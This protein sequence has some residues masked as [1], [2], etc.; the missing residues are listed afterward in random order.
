MSERTCR[1]KIIPA[2]LAAVLFLAGA[3]AAQTATTLDKDDHARR[4]WEKSPHADK[5]S[6][7]FIHWNA[8]GSIPT[9]CAKCHSTPGYRDY[10]GADGSAADVVNSTAPIGTTIQCEAC[11]TDPEKG[12]PH[13]RTYVIFPSGAKVTGLGPEAMCMECHQ[14]RASTKDVDT[15]ISGAGLANEDTPSSKLRFINVHYF[16]AAATQF[17]TVAKGGYEYAGKT[18]DA[19][20]SHI[21]GYNACI[22]CHS[23]HSLE[24]E[25]QACNTC[26][27]GVK[28]PR[29]IRYM[30]SFEDYDG[31]GD[32]K[33]GMY[34]EV[35]HLKGYLYDTMRAYA[36]TV[37]KTPIAY[38]GLTYPYFFIDL[39]DNG[40]VDSNEAN[41]ANGYNKFTARLLRAAYNYQV[42]VKDPCGYVHNGKYIIELIYDSIEDLNTKLGAGGRTASSGLRRPEMMS[43]VQSAGAARITMKDK[44]LSGKGDQLP[45]EGPYGGLS[46]AEP[47]AAGAAH[48][49]LRRTDEGHFDGSGMP[50][51]DWDDTGVVPA[52]CAK[53]HSAQGL[54]TLLE[55]GAITTGFPSANGFLCSTCHTVPPLTHPAGPV[56]F[57]SGSVVDLHDS[58]NL[59]LNCHQGRASKKTV[60]T[61]IAASKGPYSFTNIH[62]F[63]AAASFF[64]SEVHGGYEFDG[65]TYAGRNIYTNH[66]GIF[67]DCVEC[68]FSTKSPNRKQDDSD[69]HFHNAAPSPEDCVSCHGQDISQPHPGGDPE[70]FEFEGIRPAQTPDYDADGNIRESLKSEIVGLEDKLYPQIQAYGKSI[71]AP[72]VY[73]PNAYPYWFKDL[74]GNGIGDPNELVSSNG[75]RFTAPMLRAAYNLHF[76]K[77]E[78]C[79]YIHNPRYFAQLLVDS[80]GHLGGDVSPYTWR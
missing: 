26:H 53:C 48:G 60:D 62:Y 43:G 3:A 80:I 30:G 42:S 74:N 63:A 79:S 6:E 39:N 36:R 57:P 46:E 20:F 49:A 11:H 65:K 29:D 32:L 75:Y 59:C 38:D 37:V 51:R 2:A 24:V 58:S 61:A 17:G 73:D 7:A 64:G 12:I 45:A 14:G 55:T 27:I 25:I 52:T 19:R 21:P 18:Y 50:F 54:P 56:T 72:V 77:K 70:Q 34:Y 69:A 68:H 76:S 47:A 1:F 4:L 16:A 35:E 8:D 5:T 28:S 78:P 10:L 9:T 23:P 40:Q 15:S 41:S 33:E 66:M 22:V 31:D 71:G 67:T 44:G 13:D